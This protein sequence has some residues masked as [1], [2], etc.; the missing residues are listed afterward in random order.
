M[1][2]QRVP[3][4]ARRKQMSPDSINSSPIGMRSSPS[5]VITAIISSICWWRRLTCWH[6]QTISAKRR[7]R[8]DWRKRRAI[9]RGFQMTPGKIGN[10]VRK[11]ITSMRIRSSEGAPSSADYP[12]PRWRNRC[13]PRL[14][15]PM[16][17][18]ARPATPIMRCSEGYFQDQ[19]GCCLDW[20]LCSRHS[21]V[22]A[23]TG[24]PDACQ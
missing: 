24:L 16:L 6:R 3:N 11:T 2:G 15:S 18:C 8:S 14:L 10:V 22:I 5:A 4:N 7:S 19:L 21:D 13:N 12:A 9:L 1:H 23:T 17:T 20:L